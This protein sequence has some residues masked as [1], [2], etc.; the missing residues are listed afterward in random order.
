MV[1]VTIECGKYSEG[2]LDKKQWE[3]ERGIPEA[4]S[5]KEIELE[6]RLE[7]WVKVAVIYAAFMYDN[8][9]NTFYASSHL[10][11]TRALLCGYHY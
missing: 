7:E 6:L 10:I 3:Y 4:T 8:V 5:Y 1:T 11:F 2:K 9:L